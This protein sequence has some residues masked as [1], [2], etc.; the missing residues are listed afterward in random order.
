MSVDTTPSEL[1]TLDMKFNKAL[2]EY[3]TYGKE[4]S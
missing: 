1:E 3:H 4:S 2:T